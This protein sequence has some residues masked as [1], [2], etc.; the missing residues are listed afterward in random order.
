MNEK[1]AIEIIEKLKKMYPDAKCSLDFET[2]FQML[3]AEVL[4]V[5]TS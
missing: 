4:S 1:E 5:S 3:F 2:A